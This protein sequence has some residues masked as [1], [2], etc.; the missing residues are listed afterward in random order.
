MSE[1][2]INWTLLESLRD[3]PHPLLNIIDDV[4]LPHWGGEVMQEAR[5]AH[6]LL[7]LVKIPHGK[8]Y[9]QDLDAR[10]FLAIR[11][12]FDLSDRLSRLAGWHALEEGPGGLVGLYCT[13]CE[14]RWPCPTRRLAEGTYEE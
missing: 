8:G 11:Q 1:P 6:H 7:D 4:H 13:E 5:N 3:K 10:V 2:E 14:Q 9:A 12:I